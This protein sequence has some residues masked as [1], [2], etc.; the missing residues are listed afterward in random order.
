MD[1]VLTS[2]QAEFMRKTLRCEHANR[3]EA[4]CALNDI[5]STEQDVRKLQLIDERLEDLTVCLAFL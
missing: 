2:A 1:K 5:M 4:A 3:S